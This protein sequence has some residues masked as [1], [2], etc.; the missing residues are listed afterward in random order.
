MNGAVQLAERIQHNI[1]A[2]SMTHEK[3]EAASYITL[4]I[5]I[6]ETIP[7]HS[8]FSTLLITAA[9]QQLYLAKH[10]GRNR[11]KA[12]KLEYGD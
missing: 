7:R 9:D 12:G 10:T 11:I 3:S 4:S 1:A 5:G 6:A 2:L 8:Q